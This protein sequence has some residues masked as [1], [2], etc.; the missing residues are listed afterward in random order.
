LN[1]D[2]E[3]DRRSRSG[4]LV[5]DLCSGKLASGG[6]LADDEYAKN[7]DVHLAYQVVGEGS[8][9]LVLIESW[10]HHVDGFWEIPE[11]AH[12]RR[13]LAAIGRLIIFDRREP[14]CPIQ[15][16]SITSP[17]SRPRW[18]TSVQSWT[19]PGRSRPRSS[20]WPRVALLPS[21]SPPPNP[22]C[23]IRRDRWG[24]PPLVHRER[25]RGRGR[26]RGVPHRNSR[27]ANGGEQ[28]GGLAVHIGARVTATG[29]G[30]DMVVSSTVKDLV[31]GSVLTFTDR[32]E[33]DLKGVP[34]SWRLFAVED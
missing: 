21:S 3:R 11:L 23:Q 15:C 19:P 7:G 13:R 26:D 30:G 14:A 33:H 29:G 28:I 25:R 6:R 24:R 1:G 18:R 17:I 10:V 32:G 5:R 9:D 20:A 31:A 4:P 34:G 22:E 16:P 8:R 2:A 12:Q 27:L